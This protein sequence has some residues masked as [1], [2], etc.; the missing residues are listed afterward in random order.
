MDGMHKTEYELHALPLLEWFPFEY[1]WKMRTTPFEKFALA[2]IWFQLV[3]GLALIVL[4]TSALGVAPEQT[5]LVSPSTW[6]VAGPFP[7]YDRA[8]FVANRPKDGGGLRA[9]VPYRLQIGDKK[10]AG[11]A[12]AAGGWAKRVVFP[13]GKITI[14]K[15]GVY[16]VA[17]RAGTNSNW[18]GL[19]LFNVTLRRTTTK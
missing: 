17:L 7:S 14:E 11:N 1:S 8:I 15:P 10:L 6:W 4:S 9:D 16:P 12:P 13:A 2:R 18:G 19:Q 3:A 5:R